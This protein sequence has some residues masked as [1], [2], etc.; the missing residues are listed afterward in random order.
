M[1]TSTWYL[2]TSDA[3]SGSPV[4]L[5]AD[6]EQA[7]RLVREQYPNGVAVKVDV[8]HC[9]VRPVIETINEHYPIILGGKPA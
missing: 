6:K 5:I 9:V 1:P 7:D 4:A 3:T 8:S 2:V